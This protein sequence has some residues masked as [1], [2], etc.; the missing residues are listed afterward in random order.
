M[1]RT[2][3]ILIDFANVFYRAYYVAP[4]LSYNNKQTGTTF[5]FQKMIRRVSKYDA[6]TNSSDFKL[7]FV[8][9]GGR[10]TRKDIDSNYK[11]N[12]VQIE[13]ESFSQQWIDVVQMLKVGNMPI[14]QVEGYEADDLIASY[15]TENDCYIFTNDKDLE[16][17]I[18][19]GVSI[20]RY[21]KNGRIIDIDL[22]WFIDQYGF[23]PKHFPIYKA[24]VGDKS[25]NIK[26][27][28]GWGTKSTSKAIIDYD[29]DL[30]LMKKN[31]YGKI[32]N[33]LRNEWDQMLVNIELATLRTNAE[34]SVQPEYPDWQTIDTYLQTLGFSVIS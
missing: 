3:P 17:A 11:A 23:K 33:V 9:E 5:L 1:E 29:G 25:D 18:R 16:G 8:F 13:D 22:A 32:F 31:G 15:A 4:N 26:G 7:I 19:E 24:L 28:K 10:P 2:R 34:V 21:G 27:L 20:I 30:E 14:W 12:R 6:L